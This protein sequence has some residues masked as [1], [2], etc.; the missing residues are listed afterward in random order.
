M[1]G[2]LL[3]GGLVA[4]LTLPNT[5][6][7]LPHSQAVHLQLECS[8]IQ[9]WGQACIIA[10]LTAVQ[11]RDERQLA[12]SPGSRNSAERPEDVCVPHRCA[13]LLARSPV[14]GGDQPLTA[15]AVRP[16][17]RYFCAR[18]NRATAG[19]IVSV[20]KARTSCQSVE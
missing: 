3:V 13:G 1:V 7:V 16:A 20:T 18:M 12:F 8:V 6:R 9:L 14:E 2:N 10:Y 11:M 15:P 17:T 4:L 19:R 5:H